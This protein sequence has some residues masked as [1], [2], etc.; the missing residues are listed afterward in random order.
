MYSTCIE[1]HKW[2]IGLSQTN[3]LRL[4]NNWLEIHW[5]SRLAVS[6]YIVLGWSRILSNRLFNQFTYTLC[7]SANFIIYCFEIF[8]VF[9]FNWCLRNYFWVHFKIKTIFLMKMHER[10]SFGLD[11]WN[12]AM[13]SAVYFPSGEEDMF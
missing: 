5:F 7:L 9:L 13:R 8:F 10:R 3:A 4:T 2:E 6:G 1:R 12:C 11:L